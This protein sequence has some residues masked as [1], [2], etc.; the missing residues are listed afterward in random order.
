[1]TAT[2]AKPSP[3]ASTAGEEFVITRVVDAPLKRVWKAW[4]DPKQLKQWW[5]PKGFEI[6]STKVDLKPGGIF[7]YHLR[8][9]DGQD[10]WGKFVYREIVPEEQ[11]VF[12]VAFSDEMGGVTRH[13][14]HQDWPLTILSTVTFA[15]K[16]GKTSITVRWSPYE[17]TEVERKTFEEGR[18][19]MRQGWTGTFDRLVDYFA[20]A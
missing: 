3:A 15:E 16:D 8:S 17:A 2:K 9:P 4:T 14:M 10:M 18:E 12:I 19:S 1:V 7:H 6:V 13:P 20:K 5:G 11:L